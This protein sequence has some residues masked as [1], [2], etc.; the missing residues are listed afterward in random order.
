M[1]DEQA[2]SDRIQV[3]II[4]G[5]D[6]F[7]HRW[8]GATERFRAILEQH[9]H[10]EVRVTEVFDGASAATLERFDVVLL[11]Y[12]GGKRP[13]AP[14][15]RWGTEAEQALYDFVANGGGLVVL[16]G[17]FWMGETWG[18]E[19]D[20]LIEL[21]GAVMRSGSRRA[22]GQEVDVHLTDA[23]H[24]ITRGLSPTFVSPVDDKY[25]NMTFSSSPDLTVLAE[26]TDPAEA[27]LNGA[28]Y[29]VSAMPGPKIYDLAEARA[30]RGV[31]QRHPVAWVKPYGKGRVFALAIGH[32]GA[33]TIQDA[34]RG[35]KEGR[36]VGP[37]M[38]IATR[39]P[40]Y[41]TMLARGTEWAATGEVVERPLDPV[42][43]LTTD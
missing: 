26:T 27:Y 19:G 37:T 5:N 21:F 7:H 43:D 2:T 30:L 23:D 14:E 22:P 18:S 15:R 12:F 39:V 35:R 11:N 25:I 31:D 8:R 28:Y 9:P 20:E 13:T 6:H 42:D 34:H 17:S 4:T 40:H 10:F 3:L 38:D 33:S 41:V 16:H 32:V 29:A 36:E 1:S 24:P